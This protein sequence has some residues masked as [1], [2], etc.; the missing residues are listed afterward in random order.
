MRL[1][2]RGYNQLALITGGARGIGFAIAE[3]L[4]AD[5]YHVV[6]TGLSDDEV[7]AVPMHERLSAYQLDVTN[8]NSVQE[9][10]SKCDRL[11]ALINCAGMIIR[12]GGEY[13]L[14]IFKKVIDV[15]LTGTMRMC[16][17]ARKKLAE[18]G[19]GVVINT[20]SMLSIFG[21]PLTPA[22][23]ASK[24]GVVQLTKSLAVAWASDGIRVNAIAPGWIETELTKGAREDPLRTKAIIDRTPMKRWGLPGD[25]G[26]VVVH[27]CSDAARFI[28]GAV[29]PIDGG[30]SAV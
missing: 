9:I 27:L 26:G 24:G 20:A 18:S 7:A 28:T 22:Y 11:D 8:D 13:D 14:D 25:I 1:A 10:L 29:V 12:G 5:G 23:S 17:A 6:V 16:V 21:G 19:H 2:P 4:L 3:A 30:Y 15:N